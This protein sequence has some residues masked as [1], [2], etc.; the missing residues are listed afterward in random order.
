MTGA[1]LVVFLC[2]MGILLFA[3]LCELAMMKSIAERYEDLLRKHG[4]PHS[5]RK[6]GPKGF[7]ERRRSF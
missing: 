3:A 4:I 5:R 7:Y 6:N 1:P 2:V